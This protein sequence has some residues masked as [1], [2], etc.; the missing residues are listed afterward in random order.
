MQL[1]K[2]SN[3]YRTWFDA[4]VLFFIL[5]SRNPV[6]QISH[7]LQYL[8]LRGDSSILA[9]INFFIF[10]SF[11]QIQSLKIQLIFENYAALICFL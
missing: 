4:V 2:N 3:V 10:S 7:G 8:S 11:C 6:Q 9:I 1:R 5:I